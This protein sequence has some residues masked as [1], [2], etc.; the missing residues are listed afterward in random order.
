MAVVSFTA[1]GHTVSEIGFRLDEEYGVLCQWSCTAPRP[2][3]V[4]SAPSSRTVRLSPGPYLDEQPRSGSG[5]RRQVVPVVSEYGVVLFHYL[6]RPA[7]RGDPSASGPDHQAHPY[8][9]QF[10]SDCGIALRFD[11]A[12]V[13]AVTTQLQGAGVEHAGIRRLD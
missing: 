12:D 11:W 6:L 8:P 2:P 1:E 13:E 10:S 4:P 9:R 5:C 3:I 7:G